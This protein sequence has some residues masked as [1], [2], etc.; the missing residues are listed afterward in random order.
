MSHASGRTV[1][2]YRTIKVSEYAHHRLR[3]MAAVDDSSVVAVVN[4]IVRKEWRIRRIRRSL[5]MPTT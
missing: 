1:Q 5:R 4:D 2:R 3:L